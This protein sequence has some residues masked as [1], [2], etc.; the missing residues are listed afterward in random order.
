MNTSGIM[1]YNP[2]RRIHPVKFALWLGM[3]SIVMMFGALTSAYLV[4]QAAGNWLEYKMPAVFYWNTAVILLSS[5]MLHSSYR[6]YLK[7]NERRYKMG[8]LL[9]FALGIT[10][11]V[12]Q[13]IG[14]SQLFSVGV[15][16]K[17]N[18]SGSFLY[19]ITGVH[20]LHVLGGI[21]AL[22]VATFH[23][24]TLKYRVSEK[25]KNRFEL[26]LHYWHFVDVLWVYLFIFL[27]ISK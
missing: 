24:F 17:Q 26:V 9:S 8:L 5:V 12:L 14:W 27:L 1:T 18:V 22:F 3:A 6:A 19:L 25:R 2:N 10:F 21:A 20:A 7:G 4:K 11:V 23:A 13:Y 15:D 16:L